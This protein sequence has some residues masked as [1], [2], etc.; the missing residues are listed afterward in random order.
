MDDFADSFGSWLGLVIAALVLF[1]SFWVFVDAI[2]IGVRAGQVPGFK[3][4]MVPASWLV[5]CLLLWIIA[6]PYYLSVRDVLKRAQPRCPEC[7]GVVVE[8]AH[9][10]IHCGSAVERILDIRCPACR[11]PGQIRESRMNEQIE[12]PV[13]KRVFP[14]TSAVV[15]TAKV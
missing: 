13:C 2:K 5:F 9:K 14:A 10:C 8:G 7:G 11:E 1:T 4:S 6:F 15:Q 12:C 3:G